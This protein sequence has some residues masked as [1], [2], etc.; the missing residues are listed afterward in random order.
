MMSHEPTALLSYHWR[1]I[2]GIG[3]FASIIS[4]M[5]SFLW[6]LEYSATTRLLITPFVSSSGE[7]FDQFTALKSAEHIG[8]TLS[9][10]IHTTLFQ[11]RTLATSYNIHPELFETDPRK[12][13]KEWSEKIYPAVVSGTGVLSVTVFDEDTQRAYALAQAVADV[14]VTNGNEYLPGKVD[15]K[16]VDPPLLSR[17]P[18]KPNLLFRALAGLLFGMLFAAW[19]ILLEPHTQSKNEYR[20]MG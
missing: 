7:V 19:F 8:N 4:V 11:N 10:V 16:L 3:I 17:Y 15:I 20:F 12:R 1:F 5:V 18:V 9:Q 14:L 6:P 2:F 13:R